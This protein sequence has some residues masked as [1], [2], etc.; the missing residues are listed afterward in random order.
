MNWT[1]SS[2]RQGRD[3][4]VEYTEEQL[5]TFDRVWLGVGLVLLVPSAIAMLVGMGYSFVWLTRWM[6]GV[7][8]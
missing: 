3:G 1:D 6:W 2:K 4:D 7:V 8:S 5:E